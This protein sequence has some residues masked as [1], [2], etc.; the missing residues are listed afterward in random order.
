MGPNAP[1]AR[2]ADKV[3]QGLLEAPHLWCWKEEIQTDH[4]K[5]FGKGAVPGGCSQQAKGA[6]APLTE[7]W[8][9]SSPTP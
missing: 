7:A 9:P 8:S 5:T 4:Q 2:E 1:E 3:G 6:D